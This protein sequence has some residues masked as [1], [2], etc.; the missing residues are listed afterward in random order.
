LE[1]LNF[2]QEA[3]EELYKVQSINLC[4]PLVGQIVVDCMVKPPV[5]G[6][7]S[8]EQFHEEESGI[9]NT[10]HK[11]AMN[12]YETFQKLEGFECQRPQGAMYLFP[13]LK[14]PQKAI[15][16]AKSKNKS[17]DAFYCMELLEKTG[18][19]VVPGSGFGQKEGTVHFRTTFL[20]PGDFGERMEKFHQDFMKQYT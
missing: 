14:L 8:Y 16:A 19:C 3:R 17:P 15:E 13:Q 10:L 12:L 6:D 7:A 2:G 20:A 9:F 18:I 11:R 5:K 1:L 4:A